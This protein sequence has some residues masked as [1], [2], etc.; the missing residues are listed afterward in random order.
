MVTEENRELYQKHHQVSEFDEHGPLWVLDLLRKNKLERE[1]RLN[2]IENDANAIS[3]ADTVQAGLYSYEFEGDS[4]IHDTPSRYCLSSKISYLK[5]HLGK[6]IE[7]NGTKENPYRLI[8][9]PP[10]IEIKGENKDLQDLYYKTLHWIAVREKRKSIDL[11]KCVLCHTYEKIEVHH[12]S[13]ELFNED[14]RSLITVCS[15]CHEW[16]HNQQSCR[17]A[18]PKCVTPDVASR[19]RLESS[20][21]VEPSIEVTKVHV[22]PTLF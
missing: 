9:E 13:Y 12:M 21:R 17:I 19:I 11:G 20:G 2:L 22:E 14:M 4:R 16:I 15:C 18:F 10:M 3:Y 6:V 8:D 7:G 5:L 1:H